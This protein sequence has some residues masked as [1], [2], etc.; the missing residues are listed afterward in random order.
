M[1]DR[2]PWIAAGSELPTWNASPWETGLAVL[3]GM[4][5]ASFA[6]RQSFHTRKHENVHLKEVCWEGMRVRGFEYELG[7]GPLPRPL[8]RKLI[9][10]ARRTTDRLKP[11]NLSAQSSASK[12][13]RSP[14]WRRSPVCTASSTATRSYTEA[15]GSKLA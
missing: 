9:I 11:M 8:T 7:A 3:R 6:T 1:V 12:A 5:A 10:R 4:G 14:A 2:S 15:R 13:S